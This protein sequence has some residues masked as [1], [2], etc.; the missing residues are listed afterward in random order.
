MNVPTL[1]DA[2]MKSIL[3]CLFENEKIEIEEKL[4]FIDSNDR[5]KY[6]K[7]SNGSVS[8]F[9]YKEAYRDSLKTMVLNMGSTIYF[10]GYVEFLPLP[11]D[12]RSKGK[13]P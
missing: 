7:T 3:S 12:V 1:S 5:L 11:N 4:N 10:Y 9:Y 13:F 2:S 6:K 8:E